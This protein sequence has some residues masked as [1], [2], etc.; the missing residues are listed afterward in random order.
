MSTPD[1]LPIDLHDDC[2]VS[3]DILD[4]VNLIIY[5]PLKIFICMICH[6]AVPPNSLK[7]HLKQSHHGGP[8]LTQDEVDSLTEAHSILHSHFLERPHVFEKPIPGVS[9]FKAYVCLAKEGCLQTR[10]LVVLRH[11]ISAN[12]PES[13]TTEGTGFVHQLFETN[14][15]LYRVLEVPQTTIRDTNTSE[16]DFAFEFLLHQQEK[17]LEALRQGPL[18]GDSFNPFLQKYPWHEDLQGILPETI[19]H[20][21]ARPKPLDPLF[22][23]HCIATNYYEGIIEEMKSKKRGCTTILRWVNTT[24]E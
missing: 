9:F 19:A 17:C 6:I 8:Q 24:K 7:K 5:R 3:L 10:L 12:H 23:I 21:V 22:T 14:D 1:H 20:L 2:F 15:K 18:T 13:D 4:K 16:C 11:H